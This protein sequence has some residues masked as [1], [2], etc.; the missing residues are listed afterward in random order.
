MESS[1]VVEVKKE[2]LNVV[3][4]P[5]N[6]IDAVSKVTGTAKYA[7]DYAFPNMLYGKVVYADRPHARILKVD[8]SEAEKVNGVAVVLTAKDVPGQ[9]RIGGA[10]PDQPVIADDK[11]R[12]VGDCVALIAAESRRIAEEAAKKVKVEYEDLPAVFNPIDALKEDAPKIHDQG[13]LLTYYKIRKGNVDD[14]FKDADVVIE[15]EYKT[16]IVDQAYLEPDASVAVPIGDGLLIYSSTQHPFTVR[17]IVARAT[18][19]PMSKV[20]VVQATLGGGFGGKS[21]TSGLVAARAAILALK[22]SRPVKLVYTR[23]DVMRERYKRHP[24]ILKYKVGAKK[25]GSLVAMEIKFYADAGA[26]SESS[27]FVLFRSTVQCTGPYEVPNVKLDAYMVYTNNTYSGAMRGFG[28]PQ[29]NFAVESLMD[30]LAKELGMDPLD[31][32]LKNAFKNGSTTATGQVLDNHTVSIR[33]VLQKIA[34]MSNWYEKRKELGHDTGRYRRGIGL[35]CSYRGVS[36]GGEGADYGGALVTVNE[37]GSVSV[38][39]G[40]AENGQGAKTVMSQI[41]AEVLGIP[42]E[43]VYFI[44]TD[45]GFSPDSGMTVASRGTIIGGGAAKNA[46][47]IIRD[48]MAGVASELFNVPKEDI[49]FKDG[50]VF[51]KTNPKNRISFKEL[52]SVCVQKKISMTASG[53]FSLPDVHWDPETGEGIAY[54]TY[55]YSANVAEVTVDTETGEVKVNKVYAVHDPGRVVNPKT[56]RGQVYGGVVMAMGM[57]LKEDFNVVDGYPQTLNFDK[58]KLV[59]ANEI[60]EIEVAFIENPDPFGPF[61][62]KSLGE[63]ATE[64]GAPAIINAID[65]AINVRIRDLPA[66]PDKI[67]KALKK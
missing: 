14:G 65:H 64:I 30:E 46:A 41:V 4:K 58:Y 27:P 21:V 6:R 55:V 8:I 16:Q 37:D 22:T 7:A 54:V 10:V 1:M 47:M 67:L 59:R 3:G 52:A 35:A 44:D 56:A 39:S 19:L 32:R 63:P 36:L 29:V 60:P 25:D 34:E 26:Y 20:R 31:L 2:E 66:T 62:A 18:G 61:G 57:A 13:N 49:E 51:S 5:V 24:F 9:N 23:E 38:T 50:F 33:Q 43:Y 48:R 42:Y 28:S 11:V 15:R 17:S 53:F 45:T 40:I 12:Y